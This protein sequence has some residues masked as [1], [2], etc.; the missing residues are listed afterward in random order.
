[1]PESKPRRELPAGVW[2]PVSEAAKR[3]TKMFL[4][5]GAT[6]GRARTSRPTSSGCWV[7]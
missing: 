2:A 4:D 5:A 6:C 1:M 3:K 7:W